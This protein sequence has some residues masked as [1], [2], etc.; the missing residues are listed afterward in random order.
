MYRHT[1]QRQKLL[2]CSKCS[3]ALAIADVM[4]VRKMCESD[5]KNFAMKVSISKRIT[6]LAY[7]KELGSVNYS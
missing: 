1:I 4:D 7:L 5:G 6:A 3:Y 2:Y